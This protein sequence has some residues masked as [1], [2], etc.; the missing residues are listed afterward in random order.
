MRLLRP[1]GVYITRKRDPRDSRRGCFTVIARASVCLDRASTCAEHFNDMQPPLLKPRW[2][3]R[4]GNRCSRSRRHAYRTPNA[5]L[6]PAAS[7]SSGANQIAVGD[8]WTA[9]QNQID[10]SAFQR[11]LR[12]GSIESAAPDQAFRETLAHL[13]QQ[14]V[15]EA[16]LVKVGVPCR[17]V[18]AS[19][20]LRM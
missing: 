9:K 16:R 6:P 11:N 17:A 20:L 13:A 2:P 1:R 10:Q 3:R 12:H 7:R 14:R 5:P 8:V 18:S 15:A 4:S 19:T